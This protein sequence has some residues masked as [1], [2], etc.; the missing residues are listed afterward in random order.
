MA[1]LTIKGT[2]LYFNKFVS[3]DI[4]KI[5]RIFLSLHWIEN[6]FDMNKISPEIIKKVW[7]YINTLPKEE[8]DNSVEITY[9]IDCP[10][11]KIS[12][13]DFSSILKIFEK[14]GLITYAGNFEGADI[15]FLSR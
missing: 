14:Q 10:K 7:E 1:I 15:M 6:L 3:K 2:S 13:M 11:L 8:L 12:E 4:A 9:E 5:N